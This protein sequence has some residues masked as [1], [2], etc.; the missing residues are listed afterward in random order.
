MMKNLLL[1]F[2]V[3]PFLFLNQG[4]IK[5]KRV[6]S[7]FVSDLTITYD[8]EYGSNVNV[9]GEK[10]RLLLDIY[11]PKKRQISPLPL[12]ILAHGGS[13]L[14]GNKASADMVALCSGFA[15]QGYVVASISYR[16]G[17]VPQNEKGVLEAAWRGKQ[18]MKAAVRF[19]RKDASNNGK[20][21]IA[22]NQ[23]YAGGSSAGAFMGMHLAFLDVPE[24][25][26]N[27][28]DTLK[29]GGLQ[30]NSGNPGFPSHIHAVVNLSG[31]I[32]DV[33]WIG[34]NGL[35]VVS[36]HGTNDQ[37]VP[38]GT[39]FL[40]LKGSI[41]VMEVDGSL[42]IHKRL[43]SLKIKNSLYPFKGAGH[44]PYV[45]PV[46]TAQAYRDTVLKFVGTFLASLNQK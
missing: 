43:D 5:Y 13:F 44:T 34:P 23:I 8:I 14:G 36:M 2:S 1:L 18:D 17:V 24:K 32:G 46:Q 16:L 35:P 25:I 19:F 40:Y 15:R 10:Q 38:F 9:R 20:Y 29:L 4:N 21:Y 28:I 37:L 33:D 39:A 42:V 3:L 26:P 27:L 11:E 6:G 7:S 31:A 41:P 45:I 12:I 30:G 22:S